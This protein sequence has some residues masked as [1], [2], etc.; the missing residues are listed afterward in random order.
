MRL[1]YL[2]ISDYYGIPEHFDCAMNF[3]TGIIRSGYVLRQEKL[4]HLKSVQLPDMREFCRQYFKQMKIVSLIQGNLCESTAKV[5]L[6]IAE[7]NL[8]CGKIEEVSF[9]LNSDRPTNRHD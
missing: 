7:T 1:F 9:S 4:R 8:E 3:R 5:I 2:S 6:Q